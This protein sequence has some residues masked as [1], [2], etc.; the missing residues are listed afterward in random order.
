MTVV[1]DLDISAGRLDLGRTQTDIHDRTSGTVDRHDITDPEFSL[2]DD[3]DTGNDIRDQTLGA[4][5]DDK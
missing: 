5:T 1:V 4:K 2:K 3:E